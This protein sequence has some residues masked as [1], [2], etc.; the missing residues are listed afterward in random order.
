VISQLDEKYVAEVEDNINSP[1]QQDPYTTLKTELVK[2]LCPSERPAH[3][4][5]FHHRGNGWSEAIA[6]PEA[7][8]EPY[9]G[10]SWQLP[11][12]SLDQPFT[13]Q[14]PKHSGRYAWSRAGRRGPLRRSHHRDRLTVH[15]CEHQSGTWLYGAL[16]KHPRSPSSANLIIE[17][18]RSNCNERQFN[19]RDRRSRSSNCCS[20][21]NSRSSSTRRSPSRR[22]TTNTL[23]WYHRRYGGRA[24]RC[25]QPCTFNSQGN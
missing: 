18:N 21:S 7:P 10:Y 15:G 19:F 24:Q 2:R 13:H 3:S 16:A 9:T 1:P 14:H 12:H 6:V 20:N 22:D 23:C 25:S 8:Q 17:Q 5:G 4:S 11:A